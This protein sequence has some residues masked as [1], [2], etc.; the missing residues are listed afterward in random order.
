MKK[1]ILEVIVCM[2]MIATAVLPAAGIIENNEIDENDFLKAD[3][4]S[5]KNDLKL[6]EALI[7]PDADKIIQALSHSS[8]PGFYETSEYM[9]GSIA[10]GEIFLQSIGGN[11]PSTEKWNPHKE[12]NVQMEIGYALNQWWATQNPNAQVSFTYDLHTQVPTT[13][14]PIIH[15]SGVTDNTYEQLWVSEAMAY[16]GYTSGDWMDRTRAYINDLRQSKG[17]DWAF[18]IFIIDSTNDMATD[19][20]TPGAFSDNYWAYAYWGGPFCVMT[21]D[22]GPWGISRMHQVLAHE[23][24]HIFWASDEY[25]KLDEYSGYLNAMDNEGSGCLMD[26]CALCLSSGTKQQIGWRDTDGDDILDIIDTNPDTNL[27]PYS[28]NPTASTTLVYTGSAIVVPHQNN[29]PNWWNSGNDVTINTI[30]N[31][32]YRVNGGSWQDAAPVDGSYN[33]YN[34]NFTMTIGP[35]TPGTYTIEARARNSI[36]NYDL[37]PDSDTVTVVSDNNPPATPTIDGRIRNLIPNQEYTY[38]FRSTDSDGDQIRYE[39]KWGDGTS[40]LTDYL[41]SGEDVEL[42]H[43]WPGKNT[44]YNIEARAEDIYGAKSDWSTLTVATPIRRSES[45]LQPDFI[46]TFGFDVDVKAVELEPGEDYV[47][48]EILGK[49]LFMLGRNFFTVI[50]PGAFVRLYNAKGLFLQQLPFCVGIFSDYAIIG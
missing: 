1:G 27:I 42:S 18:A 32:E 37:T 25:N 24:G 33:N 50:N 6:S 23:T 28:P 17:T 44:N 10:V 8:E 11:D 21:Y 3:I 45:L 36:G 14:E 49:P 26:T 31:V 34:E 48:I 2:L 29:N 35:L 15:P 12:L 7:P 13:Y 4:Q 39:V 41:D 40:E 16:L 47:D 30:S 22:N 9:I 38:T 19:P 20:L 46:F 43:S 5:F